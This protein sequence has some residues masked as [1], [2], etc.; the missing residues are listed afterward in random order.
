[1]LAQHCQGGNESQCLHKHVDW[2][3]PVRLAGS[4]SASLKFAHKH[5]KEIQ[6]QQ[7]AHIDECPDRIPSLAPLGRTTV[8]V[9]YHV[10]SHYGFYVAFWLRPFTS[11]AID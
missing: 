2:T 1:M 5:L 10:H 4:L 8:A 9:F 11:H 3:L 7:Y 6:I